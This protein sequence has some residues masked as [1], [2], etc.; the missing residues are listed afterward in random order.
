MDY[1]VYNLT[2]NGKIKA[3]QSSSGRPSLGADA[4]TGLY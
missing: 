3:E 2:G 1:S 4:G